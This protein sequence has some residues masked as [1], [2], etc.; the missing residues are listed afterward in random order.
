MLYNLDG[1][2]RCFSTELHEDDYKIDFQDDELHGILVIGEEKTE[3]QYYAVIPKGSESKLNKSIVI[4]AFQKLLRVDLK[5][6][7]EA[8]EMLKKSNPDYYK[9]VFDAVYKEHF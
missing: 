8:F 3:I 2:I 4:M 1:K 5:Q 7:T 6:F 9:A